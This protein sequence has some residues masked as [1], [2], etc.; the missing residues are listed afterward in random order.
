MQN[1]K[2]SVIIPVYNAERYLHEAIDSIINQTIDF[3]TNI[4][5]ILINDGST[6]KSEEVCLKY[7]EQY[8]NNIIYFK[9]KNSGVSSARN[10]GIELATGEF[11]NFLD[12]DDKWSLNAFKEVLKYSNENHNIKLFSCKMVFFEAKKGNHL[13]NYK[14]K[15]NKIVNIEE[16]YDYIQLSSSSIFIKRE[17][18]GNLRYDSDIKYSED[19]KFI[20]EI[21]L[22][23]GRY[24][25]LEKPIYYYRR[26]ENDDSAVQGQTMNISWYLTTPNKVYKYLADYSKKKYNKVIPYIEYMITYELSWRIKYNTFFKMSDKD[27]KEYIKSIDSLINEIDKDVILNHRFL[28]YKL[29]S[30]LLK[31]KKIDTSII[32]G[33]K[34]QILVIDNI[35]EKD[36]KIELY[37]K[38]DKSEIDINSFKVEFNNQLVSYEKYV[39]ANDYNIET[40]DEKSLHEYIGICIKLDLTNGSLE[41]KDNNRIEPNFSLVS[42]L[43]EKLPY[44]Y[45]HL[46]NKTLLYNNGIIYIKNKSFI[47]TIKYELKNEI[48]LLKNR[49]L[50][51]LYVRFANKIIK[52]FKHKQIW[53]VSDRIMNANDNGEHFFKYMV[54]NH[55]EVK[56]LFVLSKKSKDYER[57]SKIGKVIDPNSNKYKILHSCVDYIVSSQANNYVFNPL[58]N[59]G[60]YILDQYQF[61][62]IFLQHGIIKDDLSPWLNINSKRMDMFV[63]S[64]QD[65]YNSLL[66]CNYKY[67]SSIVKLTGL[68]RFDSL[69]EKQ[70]ECKKQNKIMISFTWRTSFAV[71]LNPE[72]K[73]PLYNKDFKNTEYF[74]GINKLLNDKKLLKAL[75]DNNYKMVFCPHPNVMPQIEDFT[76]NKF[77]EVAEEPIDYQKEFAENSLLVTDYSSVF[78]D[79]AYLNKPVI[80]YQYDRDEFFEGQL[81][82][83]GYFEYEKNG[84]GPVCYNHDDLV[85]EIIKSIENK[86]IIEE[87]YKKVINKTF[88]Y[89]DKCNCER[90]Y[91]E[92]KKL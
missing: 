14:Y 15:K 19:N 34:D 83:K 43:T 78:F 8:P 71:D 54:K 40:Y 73:K 56:T 53:L 21:I 88:K 38:L 6:D 50:K 90:I 49:N 76:F 42:K 29:K 66:E 33:K 36:N 59:N 1:F 41:F 46:N 86:C 9:Q 22:N 77:I 16:D 45:H 23:E 84:F 20:N 30:F 11:I 89:H 92:I 2:F 31:K 12:S 5:L 81:Y 82:N 32:E 37:C 47:K 64:T 48:K 13:L 24:M 3:K 10:K 7:K 87:K 58:G 18:I 52:L 67:G 72:T 70:K 69:I 28:D 4:Q 80:Y 60:C 57:I 79:F 75:E 35:I 63:T 17:A 26:R 27:R 65:E 62:Y 44:S 25:V 61:K 51:L 39:L 91:N 74:K 68:P 85:K 55:P